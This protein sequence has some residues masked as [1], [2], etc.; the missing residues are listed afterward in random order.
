MTTE[1]KII[2]AGAGGQGV[3]LL[4]KIIAEAAMLEK[5]F[6]TWL[7]AYGAEVRGGT[8]NCMVI[9]SDQEIGSP[10]ISRADC[11]IIL[12]EPSFQRFKGWIKDKGIML[13]NSSLVK[14]AAEVKADIEKLPFT[15]TA[16]K[17][18]SI[19]AANMVAL[20]AFVAKTKIVKEKTVFSV[21]QN[22]I[23]GDK[24]ELFRQ[25]TAA[26]E[27]GISLIKDPLR[28]RGS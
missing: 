23:S 4:G 19:K 10:F 5:K 24:P 8:A 26:L 20:G 2:I 21:I 6:V 14:D 12:N 25:N 1:T 28:K 18:G 22:M 3:M 16:F 27:E 9:I 13:I 17:L 7:P 15:D 11:L